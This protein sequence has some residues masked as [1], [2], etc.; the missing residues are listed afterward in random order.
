MSVKL[1][2]LALNAMRGV[3]PDSGFFRSEAQLW[4]LRGA[5]DLLISSEEEYEGMVSARKLFQRMASE[6]VQGEISLNA[7]TVCGKKTRRTAQVVV[8]TALRQC[9]EK[10]GLS[11]ASLEELE[12]LEARGE[13]PKRFYYL[14]MDTDILWDAVD[15]LRSQGEY[16]TA[17][18]LEEAIR[19]FEDILGFLSEEEDDE[20]E[21]L[22]EAPLVAAAAG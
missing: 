10:N 16:Q 15:T 9:M 22:K 21:E 11:L 1:Y 17:V 5:L 14:N 12:I 18:I 20:D 3:D 7:L 4:M 19:R 2:G 8:A 6:Y 13:P